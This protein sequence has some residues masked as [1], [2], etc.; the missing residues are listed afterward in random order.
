MPSIEKLYNIYKDN[1]QVVF[2]IVS[3][4]SE[5]KVKTFMKKRGFK[6]PV[7]V[8]KFKLPDVFATQSIP[9]TFLVS[10]S[11]KIVVKETGAANWHGNKMQKIVNDLIKE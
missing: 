8:S 10:K 2:I 4:E 3:N 7:Y 9:T 5:E 6:F 1:E 11:G